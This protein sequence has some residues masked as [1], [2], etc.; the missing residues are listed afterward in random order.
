MNRET[1]EV[2]YAEVHFKNA[3]SSF[4]LPREVVVTVEWKDKLVRNAHRYSDFHL[5]NV[6]TKSNILLVP[7]Q[8]HDP[9]NA[10]NPVPTPQ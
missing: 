8:E 2:R 3:S 10:V 4:W 6:E 5:F 9:A 1:T 7:L